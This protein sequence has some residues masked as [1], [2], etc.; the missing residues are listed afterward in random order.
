VLGHADGAHPGPPSAV[1]DAE[2]LVQVQVAH[3]GPDEPGRR[4]AHL[5]NIV[6]SQRLMPKY[7]T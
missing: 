3:V 6:Q 5:S 2:G 4:H 7:K 1:G